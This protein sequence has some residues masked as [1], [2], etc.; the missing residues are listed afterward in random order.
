ME[1]FRGGT[2]ISCEVQVNRVKAAGR[3][4]CN[5][6]TTFPSSLCPSVRP[7]KGYEEMIR[8]P[9]RWTQREGP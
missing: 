9:R 4:V 3:M 8:R 7:A 5:P 1:D 2:K 6:V